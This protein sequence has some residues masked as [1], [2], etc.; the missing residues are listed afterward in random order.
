[1]SSCHRHY[2]DKGLAIA[3][4]AVSVATTASNADKD[5]S[6]DN[7]FVAEVEVI[8]REHCPFKFYWV[9]PATNKARDPSQ[10]RLRL[11]LHLRLHF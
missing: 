7:D 8:C 10:P 5:S 11:R 6:A 3:I 4:I 2:N 1:M 9:G